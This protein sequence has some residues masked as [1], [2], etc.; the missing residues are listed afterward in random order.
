[1]L[2]QS[3]RKLVGKAYKLLIEHAGKE[4]GKLIKAGPPL[5]L[6]R[7]YK[8]Y[9]LALFWLKDRVKKHLHYFGVHGIF[10]G[11]GY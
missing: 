9:H 8:R 4:N 1:M 11:A 5:T 10:Q 6:F 3:H 2:E 7:N